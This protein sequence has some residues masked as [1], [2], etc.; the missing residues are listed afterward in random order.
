MKLHGR[1]PAATSGKKTTLVAH[2]LFGLG[3][4][5]TSLE[6]LKYCTKKTGEK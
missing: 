5:S 6:L 3:F 4:T 2:L 1:N